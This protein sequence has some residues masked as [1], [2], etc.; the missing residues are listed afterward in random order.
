MKETGS[1]GEINIMFMWFFFL[2]WLNHFAYI[3]VRVICCLGWGCCAPAVQAVN[4]QN[5]QHRD[6]S[7]ASCSKRHK[8]LDYVV[9]GFPQPSLPVVLQPSPPAASRPFPAPN[10]KNRWSGQV[11]AGLQST[12]PFSAP[13]WVITGQIFLQCCEFPYVPLRIRE[14]QNY[15]DHPHPPDLLTRARKV[16][17]LCQNRRLSLSLQLLLK[18][19]ELVADPETGSPE[20]SHRQRGT[21]H[22]RSGGAAV[23]LLLDRFRTPAV[24]TRCRG[25]GC[26]RTSGSCL[27][28]PERFNDLYCHC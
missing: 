7:C 2:N 13:V 19:W 21:G 12:C 28:S 27:T 25:G 1:A 23:A 4:Q 18:A 14:S 20:G 9:W 8:W 11:T 15:C 16:A 6:C 24:Q 5:H 10:V 3:L 26:L 22:Q 17:C